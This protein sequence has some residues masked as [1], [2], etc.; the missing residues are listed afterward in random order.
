MNPICS[1]DLHGFHLFRKKLL[2]AFNIFATFLDM[3]DVT[4]NKIGKNT[5]SQGAYVLVGEADNE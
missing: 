2:T 4:G 5:C 3:E 1:F